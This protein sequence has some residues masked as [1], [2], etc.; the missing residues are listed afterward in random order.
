MQWVWSGLILFIVWKWFCCHSFEL[1]SEIS[2]AIDYGPRLIGLAYSKM[3]SCPGT[4]IPRALNVFPLHVIRNFKNNTIISHK[5]I[6]V[7]RK[8]RAKN[9][10][11]GIPTDHGKKLGASIKNIN[12]LI[13]F[14]FSSILATWCSVMAPHVKVLQIDEQYS[15][16]EAKCL[17]SNVQLDCLAASCLLERY[18]EENGKNCI[19]APIQK[20]PLNS[21]MEMLDYSQIV[22]YVQSRNRNRE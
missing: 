13:C 19:P 9:I 16:L 15:T 3:D 7:A 18:Y 8:Y 22:N 14:N 11:V 2:L 17:K 21:S 10:I 5:V 12:G 6:S 1:V 4:I 20:F